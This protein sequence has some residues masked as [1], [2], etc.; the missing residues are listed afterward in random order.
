MRNISGK[1]TEMRFTMIWIHTN[2]IC[3]VANR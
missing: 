1:L 3:N 2:M